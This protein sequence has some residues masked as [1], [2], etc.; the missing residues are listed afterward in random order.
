MVAQHTNGYRK[1]QAEDRNHD[2]FA[3]APPYPRPGSHVL[4][5]T[6]TKNVIAIK[7]ISV[8]AKGG[9]QLRTANFKKR[10]P[11]IILFN[12]HESPKNLEQQKGND[13]R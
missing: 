4:G 12:Q 2:K 5:E 3:R 11:R 7:A 13:E 8:L 6:D 1:Q 10:A 9:E